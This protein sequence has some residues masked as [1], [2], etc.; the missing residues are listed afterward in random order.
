MK[1]QLFTT[2]FATMA[3]AGAMAQQNKMPK[4][5]VGITIDQLRTDY[6]DAFSPLYGEDGFKRIMSEGRIYCN[7]QYPY[8]DIDLA[9]AVATINTGATPYNHGIISEQWI[10][11]TSLQNVSCVTETNIEGGIKREVI[12]PKNLMST[13]ISDELKMATSGKALVYS[14]SPFCEASI[15]A[16]GHA[17][18]WAM[19]IDSETGKWRGTSYYG[20]A[21]AWISYIDSSKPLPSQISSAKWT[22]MS[23]KAG[24]Y[25]YFY[26]TQQ[27][28]FS[29]TFSGEK[30]YAS[31]KTCALV[32]ENITRAAK[33]CITH[34]NAGSDNTTDLLAINYYAG[35][36]ASKSLSETT[37]ELQDTYMRLDYEIASLLKDIDRLVGLNNT[38]IFITS[39]GYDLNL[40]DQNLGKYNIP[41]GEFAINKCSALLNMY[42]IAL[43]GTG[44][45][46]DAYY[47]THIYLNNK[48][49]EDKQLKYADVLA[50]CEDFL[51]QFNGVRN[52]YTTTRI[53]QGMGT[54]E[55][56]K[57]RNG[58]YPKRSGDIIVDIAPG[59][60][61]V[62]SERGFS[63]LQ[64]DSSFDFPIL[65]YGYGIKHEVVSTPVTVD[66]IA[67]TI[68]HQIHIR[69]PNASSASP[70]F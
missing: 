27:K 40:D 1:Y 42:L 51:Y 30:K 5:V 10:D 17:A 39:T 34:G 63:K 62:N 18:N 37:T 44:Q 9:S 20:T 25:N 48:L 64:R 28:A 65:F 47:G 70:L 32:N 57:V 12:T 11:R 21:P 36:Y 60:N 52:V 2:F 6:L 69:A 53:A 35:N 14:V 43:Y 16:A 38:L 58:Y 56:T 13:T 55:Y 26:A 22:P 54:V 15:L 33:Y 49:I 4:L 66:C 41:T 8:K 46:V 24:S 68:T 19:W 59:W 67:P 23:E 31:F 61:L 3:M 7:V 45:Y 29:H 50:R